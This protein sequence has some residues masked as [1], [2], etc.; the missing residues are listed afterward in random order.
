MRCVIYLRVST[1]QQ[2]ERD[3]TEEGF[4][5]PA[6]REACVRHIRDQGWQLVDEYSDRGESARSADRPQLQAMLARIEDDRDVD[7][8]VVHKVDRLARNMEDHVAI[9]AALRRRDV[10]LVWS[11]RTSKRPPP[12]GC[13]TP[14]CSTAS[15]VREGRNVKYDLRTP[16][17][18]LFG[19]PRFEHGGLVEVMPPH[20][21]TQVSVA[22]PVLYL[23]RRQPPAP[24]CRDEALAA[25]GRLVERT[26]EEVFTV[27]TVFA[28]MANHGSRYKE[29]AVY[30][31]MQRMTRVRPIAGR[32]TLERVGW[33]GFRLLTAA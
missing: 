19:M 12:A 28:E 2:A 23:G 26:G 4:S 3:L 24:T 20:T 29:S 14:P 31:R 17:D 15:P 7:A 27:A 5:I 21:N 18:P 33:Q 22:G 25:I 10:A 30:K 11:P 16:F 8:V 1:S 6:Q 9:R 32:A 13:S